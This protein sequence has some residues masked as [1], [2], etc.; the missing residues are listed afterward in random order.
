MLLGIVSTLSCVQFKTHHKGDRQACRHAL[1]LPVSSRN[2]NDFFLRREKKAEAESAVAATASAVAATATALG[3]TRGSFKK[4]KPRVPPRSRPPP[5]VA[6]TTP[7]PPPYIPTPRPLTPLPPPPPPPPP[8]QPQTSKLKP[9]TADAPAQHSA[10]DLSQNDLQHESAAHWV[11]Y[12]NMDLLPYE[13]MGYTNHKSDTKTI[14][15]DC[16]IFG[17]SAFS[18]TDDNWVW[19]HRNVGK[20]VHKSGVTLWVNAAAKTKPR[21]GCS[22]HEHACIDN[23]EIGSAPCCI[24]I[25][26]NIMEELTRTLKRHGIHWRIASGQLTSLARDGILSPFDHDFDP[27]FEQGKVEQAVKI[28]KEEMHLSGKPSKWRDAEYYYT[29]QLAQKQQTNWSKYTVL[30][31]DFMWGTP[32]FRNPF[33]L[34]Q[35]PTFMDVGQSPE[36]PPVEQTMMRCNSKFNVLCPRNWENEVSRVDGG[37]PTKRPKWISD[38]QWAYSGYDNIIKPELSLLWK[39][40]KLRRLKET[41]EHK[42]D[43]QDRLSRFPNYWSSP[44]VQ[45][46]DAKKEQS[47]LAVEAEEAKNAIELAAKISHS[48]HNSTTATTATTATSTSKTKPFSNIQPTAKL[49]FP[50]QTTTDIQIQEKPKDDQIPNNAQR[51]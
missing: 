14:Q 21:Y 41:T 39:E 48:S 26:A 6:T 23:P 31:G 34:Q 12:P 8:P 13:S 28:I 35:T 30:A 40:T 27:V 38:E 17:A 32:S 20:M 1:Q 16:V 22:R 3:N 51:L 33:A 24:K 9:R 44:E 36:A 11:S 45:K 37:G 43:V 15:E 29:K 46:E 7:R 2:A 5:P 25:M 19:Y 10:P 50:Q 47:K 42:E 4:L 18:L 49:N